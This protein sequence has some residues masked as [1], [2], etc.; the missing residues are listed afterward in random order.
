[1]A[2]HIHSEAILGSIVQ[3][4]LPP[5]EKRESFLLMPQAAFFMSRWDQ[6]IEQQH[7]HSNVREPVI[8]FKNLAARR[9]IAGMRLVIHPLKGL[10]LAAMQAKYNFLGGKIKWSSNMFSKGR[11]RSEC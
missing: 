7:N 6:I 10:R 9:S 11:S 8:A 4:C 2:Q 5:A 3:L 1:M